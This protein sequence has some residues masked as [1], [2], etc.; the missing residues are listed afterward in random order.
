[1][2]IRLVNGKVPWEGR[3]EVRNTSISDTWG[4]VCHDLWEDVDATVACRQLG[5][6]HRGTVSLSLCLAST[7]VPMIVWLNSLSVVSFV[8]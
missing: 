2:E 8:Q 5:I 3:V 4:T 1:M 7:Q 6:G